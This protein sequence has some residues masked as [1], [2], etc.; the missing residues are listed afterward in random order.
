MPMC[1]YFKSS[2]F[3]V[4]RASQICSLANE[5]FTVDCGQWRHSNMSSI[6]SDG[7]IILRVAVSMLTCYGWSLFAEIRA[8][9]AAS[10]FDSACRQKGF[11]CSLASGMEVG[12]Q[13]ATRGRLVSRGALLSRRFAVIAPVW[14]QQADNGLQTR[15]NMTSYP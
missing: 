15:Q 3:E 9:D 11:R 1:L 5:F 14:D 4:T 10:L 7:D 13:V 12:E 6:F 2:F 8:I